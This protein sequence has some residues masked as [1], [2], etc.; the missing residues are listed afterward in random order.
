MSLRAIIGLIAHPIISAF[1]LIPGFSNY[2]NKLNGDLER[3]I[4]GHCQEDLIS[5]SSAKRQNEA[6]YL[7]PCQQPLFEL[8]QAVK[9]SQTI[10]LS[11]L[12]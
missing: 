6:P 4:N 1:G 12:T 8:P 5:K 2:F 11:D 9:F 10:N 7:A 3:W